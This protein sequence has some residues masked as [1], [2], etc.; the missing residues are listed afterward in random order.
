MQENVDKMVEILK[1]DFNIMDVVWA[2]SKDLQVLQAI[3]G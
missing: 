1:K 3:K 2:W